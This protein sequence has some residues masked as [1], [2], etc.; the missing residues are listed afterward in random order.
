MNR[1]EFSQLIDFAASQKTHF[2]KEAW[3]EFS[4]SFAKNKE[5]EV[6]VLFLSQTSW[7]GFR[8]QLESISE[9]LGIDSNLSDLVKTTR[10][11]C[12]RFSNMLKAKIH[13]ESSLQESDKR[14]VTDAGQNR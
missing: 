9:E 4:K 14:F 2:S 6:A 10:F 8:D 11:E 13:H 3:L 12:S 7:F 5:F 1:A